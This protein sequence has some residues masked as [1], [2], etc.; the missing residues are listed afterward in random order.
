MPG[1]GPSGSS[2]S[3]G[4]NAERVQADALGRAEKLDREIESRRSEMFGDLERQRDELT[5]TVSSLRTFEA[6]YRSNLTSHLRSQIETLESGH[7]EPSDPPEVVRDLPPVDGSTN[8]AAAGSDG[9]TP[10]EAGRR[11]CSD[12]GRWQPHQQ[13]PA[14]GRAARRPA[15]INAQSLRL[16]K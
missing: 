12:A 7:A 15:L 2:R 10:D 6:T 9:E 13:H 4:C 1:P 16:R 5:A 8:G 14:S 3:P 11:R